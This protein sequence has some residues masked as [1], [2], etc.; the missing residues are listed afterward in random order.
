VW[1]PA[2]NGVNEALNEKTNDETVE[3]T[4]GVGAD[5]IKY[6]NTRQIMSDMLT[7]MED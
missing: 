3:Y 2:K 4:E 5:A 1:Q 6:E 7:I